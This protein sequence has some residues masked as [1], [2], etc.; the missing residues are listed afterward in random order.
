MWMQMCECGCRCV[1]VNADVSNGQKILLEGAL[2]L[3]LQEAVSF[4][5]WVLETELQ[6]SVNTA[7]SLN[8]CTI[9]RAPEHCVNVRNRKWTISSPED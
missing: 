4:V 2:D 1:N 9:S 3:E 8:L 5:R 6:S 7:S